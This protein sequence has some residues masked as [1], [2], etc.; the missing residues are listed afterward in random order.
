MILDTETIAVLAKAEKLEQYFES[1][2]NVVNSRSNEKAFDFSPS[3]LQ[4]NLRFA[5]LQSDEACNHMGEYRTSRVSDRLGSTN[6]TFKRHSTI[7]D[8]I[9]SSLINEATEIVPRLLN[10]QKTMKDRA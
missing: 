6:L 10:R 2:F 3:S 1:H 9:E 5:D 4:Q 7:N 8:H